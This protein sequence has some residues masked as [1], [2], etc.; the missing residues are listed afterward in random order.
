M[1]GHERRGLELRGVRRTRER[2]RE[3][4]GRERVLLK[5]REGGEAD[6]K[7]LEG[8]ELRRKRDALLP[9]IVIEIRVHGR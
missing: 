4:K 7:L 5:R 9:V 2:V 1:R 3:R 6:G 8:R